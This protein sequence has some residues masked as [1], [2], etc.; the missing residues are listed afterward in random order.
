MFLGRLLAAATL[1]LASPN[2]L[3]VKGNIGNMIYRS[4]L[5]NVMCDGCGKYHEEVYLIVMG[6]YF[7]QVWSYV[8]C[9]PCVTSMHM[10]YMWVMKDPS[11]SMNVVVRG[12]N[13]QINDML[14]WGKPIN[15]RTAPLYPLPDV[16]IQG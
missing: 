9:V 3:H 8:F 13:I 11:R 1:G 6:D 2:S 7:D 10:N 4:A 14:V 15:A 16:A 12:Q 5:D